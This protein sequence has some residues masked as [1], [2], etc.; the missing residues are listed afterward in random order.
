M[1][2]RHSWRVVLAFALLWLL[3]QSAEGVG[4]LWLHN[5]AVR[6]VLM[7]ASVLLAWPL[8][9]WLG[10]RGF[11]AYAL[12]GDG[13]WRWLPGCL[14]LAVLAKFVAVWAGLRLGVYVADAQAPAATPADLMA[15]LPM[16][17]LGTFVP[18][19]AEDIL[20][21]G[22][23]YRAAGIR[24]RSGALFVLVS[25][26]IF[27][28]N[29]I[30]RLGNGRQ[31]W[32]LLFAFGLPYAT[33]LWRSGS[34]WAAL[35]LESG[36][37]LAGIADAGGIA[38]RTRRCHPVHCGASGDVGHRAAGDLASSRKKV[39]AVSWLREPYWLIEG[40]VV[41]AGRGAGR[42]CQTRQGEQQVRTGLDTGRQGAASL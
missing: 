4:M 32:G 11:G 18:S 21:R 5:T 19:L 38:W 9:R 34:L 27:V 37:R 7:T 40:R 35:G 13:W 14:L 30:Y 1:A 29:H 24:W 33:A 2:M 10:W 31:E 26:A 6:D 16:L 17:L 8:S 22:Y 41:G 39:D 3:Y 12:D 23:W 28:F 15:A 25:A 42:Q 20:T 36:Q